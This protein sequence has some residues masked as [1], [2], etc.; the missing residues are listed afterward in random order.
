MH[1]NVIVTQR[2]KLYSKMKVI[3][4]KIVDMQT[5]I[6]HL[7]TWFAFVSTLTYFES[8]KIEHFINCCKLKICFTISKI[9]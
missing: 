9:A 8:S 4:H 2:T 6:I 1:E 5:Y 7:I 3:K